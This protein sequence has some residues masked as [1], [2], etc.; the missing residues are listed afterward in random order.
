MPLNEV[1]CIMGK[2]KPSEHPIPRASRPS[3]V[4]ESFDFLSKTR[5]RL[6]SPLVD[7]HRY[8][9]RYPWVSV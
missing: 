6:F 7:D 1:L 3:L 4:G 2:K 9:A 5:Y 8:H